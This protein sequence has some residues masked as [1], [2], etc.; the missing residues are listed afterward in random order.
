[1]EVPQTITCVECGAP[2]ALLTHL[3]PEGELEP[4]EVVTYVCPDCGQRLD[5][6][7]E[8]DEGEGE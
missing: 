6:I 5:V 8:A 1:M 2:A 7:L 4:G 3:P